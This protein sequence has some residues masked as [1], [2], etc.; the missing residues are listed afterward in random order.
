LYS[1]HS[2]DPLIGLLRAGVGLTS[3]ADPELPYGIA[4]SG[5]TLFIYL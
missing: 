2:G 1:Q 3:C 4:E 5:N